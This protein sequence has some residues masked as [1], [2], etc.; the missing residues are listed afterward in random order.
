MKYLP[1]GM[2][3]SLSHREEA[4]AE[5]RKIEAMLRCD[6]AVIVRAAVIGKL[7]ASGVGA[8][9]TKGSRA[10][11]DNYRD[12]TDDIPVW[13][14]AG[15]IKRWNRHE[16]T[17]A[18]LGRAPNYDFAP[19]PPNLRVICLAI[20]RPYRE[21]L[22]AIDD[23][24]AAKPLSELLDEGGSKSETVRKGFEKLSSSLG[25][26]IDPHQRTVAEPLDVNAVLARGRSARPHPEPESAE[27]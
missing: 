16:V 17:A 15:A 25:S 5:R 4:T 1:A 22:Q 10:R 27:G 12:A 18:D 2:S 19:S 14:I 20:T 21:A 13:A 24:L 6:E 23:L 26:V 8:T 7:L 3:L 11:S 9:D